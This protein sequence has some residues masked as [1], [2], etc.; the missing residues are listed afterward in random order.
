MKDILIWEIK[1][2]RNYIMWWSIAVFLLMI[3]L[4]SIYPSIHK[5]AQQLNQVMSQLPDSIKA[6]RGSSDITSPVGYLNGELYYMTL[7]MLFIIMS[8]GLGAS[9][10]AKD[11]QAH[12]LELLLSRPISRGALLAGKALSAV[13]IVGFV[14]G[15]GF[16]AT[17]LLSKIVGIDIGFWHLFVAN[18]YCL[19]FS[20]AYGAIAFLLTATS[21][22]RRASIGIATLVAFGGYLLASM[23]SL[24][25]WVANAAKALPYH[26]YDPYQILVGHTSP[27][28]GI[29]LAA[30]FITCAAVSYLSF[31]RRDIE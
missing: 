19:V 1:Q 31:R 14:G 2:R 28:L 18:L 16:V 15:V 27:G 30:I 26:Y 13:A 4:L 24:T 8:I 21:I 3:M 11:E 12:T 9:V 5:E 10:L 20:L 25:T 7:P 29:Y 22:A 17:L 6:M 23:S